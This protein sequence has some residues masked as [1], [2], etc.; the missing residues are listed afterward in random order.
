MYF[1]TWMNP[2]L[3]ISFK[4]IQLWI[5]LS[6]ADSWD[7]I[8]LIYWTTPTVFIHTI[9][10]CRVGYTVAISSNAGN[11]QSCYGYFKKFI[12]FKFLQRLYRNIMNLPH[13]LIIILFLS[14]FSLWTCSFSLNDSKSL[15]RSFGLF[16]VF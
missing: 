11:Y 7:K 8:H 4:K 5:V 15:R 14:S 10:L 3:L 2:L 13:F 12:F 9:F 6:I 16:S 1:G